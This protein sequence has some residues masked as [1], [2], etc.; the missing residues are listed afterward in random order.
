MMEFTRHQLKIQ[1]PRTLEIFVF[2]CGRKF[3]IFYFYFKL[4][5][6]D[7][8]YNTSHQRGIRIN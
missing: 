2:M 4:H 3:E 5:D 6:C 1:Y 8:I 7:F